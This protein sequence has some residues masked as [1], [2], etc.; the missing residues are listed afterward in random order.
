MNDLRTDIPKPDQP[1]HH[2]QLEASKFDKVEMR[3]LA[4]FGQVDEAG[5][6]AEQVLKHIRRPDGEWRHPMMAAKA[7]LA[8]EPASR[9]PEVVELLDRIAEL[10]AA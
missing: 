4:L 1:R 8:L 3:L 10:S 6:L 5:D 2:Y 9:S 7:M